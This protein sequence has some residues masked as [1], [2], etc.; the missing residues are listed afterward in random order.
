[1]E[2]IFTFVSEWE[3]GWEMKGSCWRCCGVPLAAHTHF[4]L[5][6]ALLSLSL[7]LDVELKLSAGV[8]RKKGEGEGR[9]ARV[10]T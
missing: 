8:A 10:Q 4:S 5:T 6:R 2:Q 7:S 9:V 1:M 3:D